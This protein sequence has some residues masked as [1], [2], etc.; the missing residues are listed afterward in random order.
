VSL[1]LVNDLLGLIV[2]PL[3]AVQV[4]LKRAKKDVQ[5]RVARWYI[6]TPKIAIWVKFWRAL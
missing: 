3:E 4:S 2:L 5:T 1:Q 6:Y